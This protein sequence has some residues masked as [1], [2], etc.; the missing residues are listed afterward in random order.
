MCFNNVTLTADL[1][2]AIKIISQSRNSDR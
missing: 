1:L 2:I